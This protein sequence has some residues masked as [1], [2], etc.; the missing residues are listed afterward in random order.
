M[1]QLLISTVA[2]LAFAQP[3]T[4]GPSNDAADLVAYRVIPSA[5][6]SAIKRYDEPHYVVFERGAAPS[7]DLLVFMSGSGGRPENAS[8]FLHV[9]AGQGYRVVSLAYNDLPAVVAICTRDPDPACSGDVRQKR[10]FGDNVTRKI[11]DTPAESIVNRLVKL[12]RTLDHDHPSEGWGG[13]LAD[14]GPRWDRIAVAGHS[15]GAGM[16]AYIA[17]RRSVARVILFS[18]PW[19]N[20]GRGLLASWVLKGSGATPPE[21]WFGAYHKKENTAN[22]IAEAYRALHVPQQNIRVFTLPPARMVGDNPY[23]LR[24]V[25][26]GA[27]PRAPDGSPAYASEWRFL[28]GTSR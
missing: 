9:A 26:N 27:T 14:D 5:T 23:H 22:L 1:K 18:S 16:A 2:L 8:D 10:I 3:M 4:A 17:Q 13:Y 11:D 20:S 28:T 24:M 12:L 7:A 15:Q 21:R 19:D 25:G 6:D